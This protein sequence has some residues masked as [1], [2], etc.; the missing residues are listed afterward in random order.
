MRILL[1]GATG[2]IGS[3]VG[4]TL[5]SEG[6]TVVGVT[7]EHTRNG[8]VNWI[9]LDIADATDP[10][11]WWASMLSSIALASFRTVRAIPR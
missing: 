3:A 2:L 5:R 6:H 8:N 9:T 10:K 1:T 11:D 7:H 4:V